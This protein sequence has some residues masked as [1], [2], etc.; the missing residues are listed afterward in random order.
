MRNAPSS[1]RGLVVDNRV[2]PATAFA[3]MQSDVPAG[4]T[5]SEWRVARSRAR[6]TADLD[7]RR[8][9]RAALVAKLSRWIDQR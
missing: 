9:R 8:Q 4:M 7:A 3:Y 6:R 1:L 2:V 5:L